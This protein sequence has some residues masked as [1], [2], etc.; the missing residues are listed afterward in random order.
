MLLSLLA[1]LIFTPF[2]AGLLKD[3]DILHTAFT[4]LHPGL[5]RYNTPE[6]IESHF[7]RLRQDFGKA[8]DLKAAYIAL[9]E[10]TAK[11]QCGH[12]YPN[13][14]NQP[15]EVAKPIFEGQNRIPFHFRWIGDSMV[16]TE[17]LT[18]DHAL[19]PGTVV[20]KIN[21]IPTGEILAKLMKIARADG[22][23]DAKRRAILCSTG[24]SKYEAFDV[25]FPLYFPIPEGG[26]SITTGSKTVA[27]PALSAQDRIAE[28]KRKRSAGTQGEPWRLTYPKPGVAQL[29]MPTW[30]LY[31][32][33]WDWRGYLAKTF[34]SLQEQHTQGLIL[35]LTGNEG[36]ENVG[37]ELVSYLTSKDPASSL[38]KTYTRFKTAPV[39]L[40][41]YFDT[42]DP[43]FYDWSKSCD[44]FQSIS[45][46][47]ASYFRM[48]LFER[49]GEDVIMPKKTRFKGKVA[50]IT[51]STNSSATFLFAQKVRLLKLGTLIGETT[52]GNQRGI[53]GSAFYFMT[54]PNS[55]IEVDLPLCA[56]FAASLLPNAGLTPDIAV[57]T[58]AEDIS[59]GR[60]PAIERAINFVQVSGDIRKE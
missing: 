23:N 18:P 7:A 6:Q 28:A 24:D 12:T 30:A 49:S 53:N 45:Q 38:Y 44:S 59:A 43:A 11:I 19:R 31:N 56:Q 22:G 51:E 21:G 27:I 3:A 46:G 58:T 32:D 48:H 47:H 15:P 52:G 9:S 10:F 34:Q 50:V 5:Y 8:S 20:R 39:S 55:H 41:P 25:Y 40:K 35:D 17:D 42:W 57:E 4:T 29:T 37:D 26:F 1:P 16:V 33:K 13:F 2:Q 54:L 36:G 60:N 14:F